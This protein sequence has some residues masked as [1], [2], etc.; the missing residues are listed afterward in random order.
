V[1]YLAKAGVQ[2]AAVVDGT[3]GNFY[4]DAQGLLFSPD[5]LHVA[6]VANIEGKEVLLV[7]GKKQ[8]SY[9]YISSKTK[10][11]MTVLYSPDGKSMAYGAQIKDMWTVVVNGKQGKFYDAVAGLVFSPDSAQAAYAAQT[12]DKWAAVAN[13][14]E[15]KA[16]DAISRLLF[17]P[18]G[19][20]LAYL[21]DS[22]EKKVLVLDEVE[23]KPY[24]SIVETESMKLLHRCKDEVCWDAFYIEKPFLFS[25]DSKRVAYVAK[26]GEKRFNASEKWSAVVDGKEERPY[27][28]IGGLNFSPDSRHVAY[29]AGAGAKQFVVADGK[30]GKRYDGLVKGTRCAFDSSNELHYLAKKNTSSDGKSYD[31]VLVE[32]SMQ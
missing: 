30:E 8:A 6:Y 10:G 11:D 2:W 24:A 9:D 13:G 17:S 1:A 16:Y 22:G 4:D 20:R 7:D 25:P 28:G 32:E 3:E 21:A 29:V 5:S 31:V 15:S 26:V 12:D 23:G 27:D 19:R 14:K 18:D